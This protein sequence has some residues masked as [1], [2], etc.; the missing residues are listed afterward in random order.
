[1]K[2]A[3]FFHKNETKEVLRLTTPGRMKKPLKTSFCCGEVAG[4]FPN[5]EIRILEVPL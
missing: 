3:E 2:T 4:R 5:S 1:M